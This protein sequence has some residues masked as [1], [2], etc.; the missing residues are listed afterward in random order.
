MFLPSIYLF[1]ALLLR[2]FYQISAYLAKIK[3]NLQE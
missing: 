3:R 1:D 2:Y